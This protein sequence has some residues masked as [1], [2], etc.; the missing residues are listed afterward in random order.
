MLKLYYAP[1]T[2]AMAAHIALEEAGAD[3]EGIV[4]DFS[5]KQ[6]QSPEFLAINSKARV[7]VLVSHAGALT[8]TPAILAYIAQTYPDAQLAPLNNPFEFARVQAFNNYLSSTVH[9]AHAH[10]LRGHRWADEPSSLDDMNR[11][12]PENMSALMQ[13]IEDTMF[14]GPW[15]MGETYSICDPYLYTIARWLKSDRVEVAK[16]P[17]IQVHMARVEARPAVKA[18]LPHH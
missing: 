6:Q 12:V 2:C 15:V 8:E 16:F 10:K 5:K 7:P 1:G 9:V 4:L 17:K 18:I 13:M 14:E 11:K 3:Y